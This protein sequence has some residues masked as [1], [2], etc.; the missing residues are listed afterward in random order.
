MNVNGDS[1]RNHR[2]R[3]N[4]SRTKSS[5]RAIARPSSIARILRA[6]TST[7]SAAADCVANV[8]AEA[9][10]GAHGGGFLDA[11]SLDSARSGGDAGAGRQRAP[12]RAAAS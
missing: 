11:G 9:L 12:R 1:Q 5:V 4:T 10:A 3:R 8:H 2:L 6:R 7:G